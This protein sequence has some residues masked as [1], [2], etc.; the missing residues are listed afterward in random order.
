MHYCIG[1]SL[2]VGA[3]LIYTSQI[4]WSIMMLV[5]FGCF[6]LMGSCLTDHESMKKAACNVQRI[7]Q[8]A[9]IVHCFIA[10]RAAAMVMLR[11]H[12]ILRDVV[13]LLAAVLSC[14]RTHVLSPHGT[15]TMRKVCAIAQHLLHDLGNL[16]SCNP[17]YCTLLRGQSP[18]WRQQQHQKQTGCRTS[19]VVRRVE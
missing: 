14:C 2:A 5:L 9:Y 1:I 11:L 12:C 10:G 4:P 18:P 16:V 17:L 8:V 3:A 7:P 6:W 19:A 13:P 15:H